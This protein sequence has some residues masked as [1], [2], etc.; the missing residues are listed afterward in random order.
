MANS[1][2]KH[3]LLTY[4]ERGYLATYV[5][6]MNYFFRL[7]ESLHQEDYLRPLKT[8]VMGCPRQACGRFRWKI[9]AI[10]AATSNCIITSVI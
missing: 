4:P 8:L 6:I 10:V 3:K 5:F 7:I 1:Y 9:S 2:K